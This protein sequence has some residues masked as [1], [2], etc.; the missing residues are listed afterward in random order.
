TATGSTTSAACAS[1]STSSKNSAWPSSRPTPAGRTN[2]KPAPAIPGKPPHNTVGAARLTCGR[3]PDQHTNN[4]VKPKRE[5]LTSRRML[6]GG[7]RGCD[8]GGYDNLTRG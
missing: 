5:D 1:S 2:A 6:F 7:L 4:Q 8:L 3:P